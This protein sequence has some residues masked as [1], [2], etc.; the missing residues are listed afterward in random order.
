MKERYSLASVAGLLARVLE[1]QGRIDE[2]E[3]I[4][5]IA[6]EV[7]AP[8]DMDAQSIWRG[9][10]ARVLA[11]QGRL[12]EA[13]RLAREAAEIRA[14]A[15]TPVLRAE[16]LMDLAVVLEEAGRHEEADAALAEALELAQAKGD[17]ATAAQITLRRA[18]YAEAPRS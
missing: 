3:E 10:R 8:D 5:R 16:A 9:A 15:D 6:E 1:L 11:R 18:R 4:T 7:A 17:A 12:D 13:D 2:A 14:Q